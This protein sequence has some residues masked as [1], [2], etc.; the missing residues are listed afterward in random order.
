MVSESSPNMKYIWPD[1]GSP[2]TKKNILFG[3]FLGIAPNASYTSPLISYVP[4]S[5]VSVTPKSPHVSKAVIIFQH[6]D[7]MTRHMGPQL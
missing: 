5:I 2:Y 1:N 6:P 3:V 7:H 4:F